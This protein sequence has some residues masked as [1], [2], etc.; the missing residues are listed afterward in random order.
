[1]NVDLVALA[2]KV[3]WTYVNQAPN[4]QID[5]LINEAFIGCVEAIQSYDA[6]RG[7]LSTWAWHSAKRRLQRI[8]YNERKHAANVPIT[9]VAEP[10][11]DVRPLWDLL[12]QMG[13]KARQ[14]C[15]IVIENP[16]LLVLGKTRSKR[17]IREELRGLGW[18]HREIDRAFQ[19]ITAVVRS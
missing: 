4:M 3:A 18:K 11:T 16:E 19:E 15:N 6:A 8:L 13:D 10:T 17:I 5:E 14:V 12:E 9:E 7:A 1:M 2:R